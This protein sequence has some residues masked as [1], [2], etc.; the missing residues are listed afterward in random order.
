METSMTRRK[1]SPR[2]I[3]E[4][5]DNVD[6][7]KGFLQLVDCDCELPE[8]LCNV[9]QGKCSCGKLVEH[10]HCKHCGGIAEVGFDEDIEGK[11]RRSI[12]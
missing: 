6:R 1:I 11:P 5:F 7:F 4:T 12:I 2:R 9:A 10:C 3:L 8:V